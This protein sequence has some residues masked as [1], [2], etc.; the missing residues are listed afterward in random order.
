[1]YNKTKSFG[2]SKVMNEIIIIFIKNGL[3]IL[4]FCPI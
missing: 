2:K 4:R 1:M 3:Y